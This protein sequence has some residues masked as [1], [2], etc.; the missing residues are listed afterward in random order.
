MIVAKPD[1]VKKMNSLVKWAAFLPPEEG[2]PKAHEQPTLFIAVLQDNSVPGDLNTDTGIALANMTLAAWAKGVG[3]CIMGAIDRPKIC[4]MLG[5]T[6]PL[7][8]HTVIAFGYPSHTARIVEMQG[9]SNHY[10]LDAER[11]YC[12]PKRREEELARYF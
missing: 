12:V 2:T 7:K 3:S 10:Y 4:E 1:D 11:N 8:L 5:I 6:E 9:E